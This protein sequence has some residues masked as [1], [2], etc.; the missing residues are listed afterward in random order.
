MELS[1]QTLSVLNNFKTI[2]SNLVFREGNVI[3]TIADAKNVM[4]SATIDNEI[5]REFGI[6]DLSEFLATLNLVDSPVLKLHKDHAII[7]SPSGRSRIKYFFSDHSSAR[8]LPSL[9]QPNPLSRI[10]SR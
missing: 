2:Q 10:S 6:Y 4:A 9:F 1:E 8:R 7:E 3:K 5:T